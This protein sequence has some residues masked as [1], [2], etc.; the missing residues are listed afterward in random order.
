[1]V[2]LAGFVEVNLE[3]DHLLATIL[4]VLHQTHLEL[5]ILVALLGELLLEV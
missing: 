5:F 1:M 2:V 4:E 3:L